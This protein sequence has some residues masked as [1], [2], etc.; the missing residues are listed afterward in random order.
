MKEIEE[1]NKT[2]ELDPLKTKTQEPYRNLQAAVFERHMKDLGA[3]PKDSSKLQ[4]IRGSNWIQKRDKIGAIDWLLE[5]PSEWGFSFHQ[6]CQTLGVSKMHI[7]E[8]IGIADLTRSQIMEKVGLSSGSP[9][10]NEPAEAA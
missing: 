1:Q 8:K 2:T 9:C 10:S 7:F 5:G 3:M 4:T 6:I